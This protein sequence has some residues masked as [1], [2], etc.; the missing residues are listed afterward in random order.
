MSAGNSLCCRIHHVPFTWFENENWRRLSWTNSRMH[1]VSINSFRAFSLLL[2]TVTLLDSKKSAVAFHEN[3]DERCGTGHDETVKM[4][5]NSLTD[6]RDDEVN[7][8]ILTIQWNFHSKLKWNWCRSSALPVADVQ[9]VALQCLAGRSPWR[10]SGNRTTG[11]HPVVV[12]IDHKKWWRQDSQVCFENTSLWF[13]ITMFR[14][15]TFLANVFRFVLSPATAQKR[16]VA[17]R[18]AEY[19]FVKHWNSFIKFGQVSMR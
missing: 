18:F 5:S 8:G 17:W 14:L 13:Y 2:S 19:S 3:N 15:C 4:A 6:S 10:R 16:G 9:H 12:T 1:C 11:R 7:Y